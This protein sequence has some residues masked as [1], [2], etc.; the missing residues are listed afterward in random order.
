PCA[1]T[2]HAFRRSV[3]RCGAPTSAV[4]PRVAFAIPSTACRAARTKPGRRRRSSGG[5]P[6]TTSS[7][8]RTRSAFAARARPSHSTTRAALP[9]TSPTTL[10]ICAS[11]SLIGFRLPVENS[12][13][14]LRER[15]AAPRHVEDDG[16]EEDREAEPAEKRRV[17]LLADDAQHGGDDEHEHEPEPQGVSAHT[18]ASMAIVI[19]ERFRG[20]E[21]SG[22]GG[23]SC[24]LFAAGQEAEV[25]LRLPPPLR[26]PL[27]RVDGR[28]LAGAELVAEVRPG[29]VDLEAPQPV[30]WEEAVAAAS[31][32]PGR[33]EATG[34]ST[35]P[36]PPSS[37][38]QAVS[39]GSRAPSGSSRAADRV[40]PPATSQRSPPSA[41]SSTRSPRS[42]GCRYSSTARRGPAS[43]PAH[44]SSR[45]AQ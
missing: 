45:G 20:P 27:E 29:S 28:I 5:Y 31:S 33:S 21:A 36:A 2:K 7:G 16:A 40:S 10:L 18:G 11:A 25:T 24:G 3:S 19:D 37:P 14:A 4:M 32:S 43:R 22:D 12:S 39:S 6:V 38:T 17:L 35:G 34:A 30:G 8:K 26:T 41:T 23:Y 1:S 9:S 42:T 44:A 15:G 13:T